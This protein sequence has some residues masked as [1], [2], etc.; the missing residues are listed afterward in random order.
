[1]LNKLKRCFWISYVLPAELGHLELEQRRQQI[2]FGLGK[3]IVVVS[4]TP[5]DWRCTLIEKT[6]WQ[7]LNCHNFVDESPK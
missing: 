1:M 5:S 4:A 2:E 6:H 7:I 3:L